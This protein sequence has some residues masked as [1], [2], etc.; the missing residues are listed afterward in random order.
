M[1]ESISDSLRRFEVGFTVNGEP[2]RSLIERACYFTRLGAWRR[3]R[4]LQADA[5]PGVRY[6]IVDRQPRP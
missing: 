2:R 6:V 3:C 4:K 1:S 5:P